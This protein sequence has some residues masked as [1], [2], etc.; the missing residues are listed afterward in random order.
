MPSETD[1]ANLALGKL[2]GA[3]D[4]ITGNAFI[5]DINDSDKVSQWM[6]INFPRARRRSIKDLATAGS[7]FR[8][9]LRFSG[10]GAQL[11]SDDLPETGNWTHA[12][13]LPGDCLAVISQFDEDM[14]ATRRQPADYV[15]N[16][17]NITYQWEIIANSAGT[18][19]ILL[20]DTLSD[21]DQVTAFIEYV[22]DTPSTGGF[23]EEL[24]QCIATLLAAEVVPVIEAGDEAANLMLT[25][26]IQLAVPDAKRANGTDYNNSARPIA[27]YKGGRNEVLLN[28]RFL[29]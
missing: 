20:T 28:A 26:Y 10:L 15:S 14:I 4:A 16:I 27:D 7:P 22:V 29:R 21:T 3:G 5:S 24:I 6:K 23:S 19:R 17:A 1:I 18:G 13:N 11:S 9:T 2:G 25:K 12:F 8:S